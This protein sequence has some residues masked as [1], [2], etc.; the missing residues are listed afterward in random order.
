LILQREQIKSQL[1]QSKQAAAYDAFKTALEDR[2]KKEGK[3]TMNADV[4][5]RLT[6]IT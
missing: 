1:L 3:L 5:K 4:V 6:T 2:L